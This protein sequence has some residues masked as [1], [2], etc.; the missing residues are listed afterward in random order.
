ML[1][2]ALKGH[3]SCTVESVGTVGNMQEREYPLH[4]GPKTGRA[5]PVAKAEVGHTQS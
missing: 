4:R 2:S 3:K 5:K 1:A